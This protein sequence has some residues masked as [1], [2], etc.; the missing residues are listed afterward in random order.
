MNQSVNVSVD[1]V[2]S[3]Y[4]RPAAP[5][6][7]QDRTA[8][9]RAGQKPQGERWVG[10]QG[11]LDPGTDH[12]QRRLIAAQEFGGAVGLPVQRL[13]FH[14]DTELDPCCVSVSST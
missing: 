2:N 14:A 4:G 8:S 13:D 3:C 7:Q 9:L 11:A 10:A 12:E 5:A 1:V 6:A